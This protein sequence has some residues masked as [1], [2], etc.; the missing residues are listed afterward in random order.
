[1]VRKKPTWFSKTKNAVSIL[2]DTAV[3]MLLALGYAENSL[4]I[5]ICRVGVSG[6]MNALNVFLKDEE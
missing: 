6:V 4:I 3:V 2:S 5:L 1:M